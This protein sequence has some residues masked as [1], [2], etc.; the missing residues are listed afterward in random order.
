MAILSTPLGYVHEVR[1]I[2]RAM[3]HYPE[4]V[5]RRGYQI[6]TAK[7]GMVLKIVMNAYAAFRNSWDLAVG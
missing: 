3:G 6:L 2:V 1:S 7:A 4:G 5:K